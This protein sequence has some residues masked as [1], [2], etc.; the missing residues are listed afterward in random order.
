M[1]GD[2][3][4]LPLDVAAAVPSWL[5]AAGVAGGQV[6]DAMVG[7]AAHEAGMTLAT[8]DARAARTYEALGVRYE[9]VG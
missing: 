3:L 9:V 6:Y 2:P 7:L 4:P 5:A 1:F 8:R